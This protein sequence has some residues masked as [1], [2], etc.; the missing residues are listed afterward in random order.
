MVLTHFGAVVGVIMSEDKKQMEELRSL[1]TKGFVKIYFLHF[2]IDSILCIFNTVHSLGNHVR[3][4]TAELLRSI[5]GQNPQLTRQGIQNQI[6]QSQVQQTIQRLRNTVSIME[7]L[8]KM[9]KSKSNGP[10]NDKTK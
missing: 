1:I 6:S 4:F 2:P 10:K 8:D 5:D 7:H 3:P 9:D